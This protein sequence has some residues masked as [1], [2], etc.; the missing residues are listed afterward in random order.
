[1]INSISD[2]LKVPFL[3]INSQIF[4]KCIKIY[5]LLALISNDNFKLFGL[6]IFKLKLK[7]YNLCQFYTFLENLTLLYNNL[8]DPIFTKIRL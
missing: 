2:M 6:Y 3:A 8:I 5:V 7:F 4:C 1:M